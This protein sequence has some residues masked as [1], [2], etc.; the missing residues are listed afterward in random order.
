[1]GTILGDAIGKMLLNFASPKQGNQIQNH[2]SELEYVLESK[3]TT[4]LW[5]LYYVK[6][7]FCAQINSYR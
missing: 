2:L 6:E 7:I 5:L 1:M 4:Q 3:A